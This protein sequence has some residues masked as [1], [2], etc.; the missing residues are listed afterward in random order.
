[1]S[2]T[3]RIKSL[4]TGCECQVPSHTLSGMC[5]WQTYLSKMSSTF[6]LAVRKFSTSQAVK[7]AGGEVPAGFAALKQKQ[8]MFNIDNGLR[9]HE[10]GG[11]M[12]MV[13]YNTTLGF[14][15]VGGI[16]WVKTVYGMAY[17]KKG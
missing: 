13:L 8:K 9:I 4:L 15:I 3:S 10:R 11:V 17:P 7:S 14:I 2:S 16:L 1:M 6:R 12:D 5:K